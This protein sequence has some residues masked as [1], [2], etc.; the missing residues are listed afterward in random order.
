MVVVGTAVLAPQLAIY[1]QATGRVLV[2]SYGSM[3]FTFLSPHIWGVLF[4]VQKGLFF[5]SPLL[6]AAIAGFVGGRSEEAAVSCR[7]GAS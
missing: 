7:H 3:G 4:S 6:L 1:Y 5:W 2:S